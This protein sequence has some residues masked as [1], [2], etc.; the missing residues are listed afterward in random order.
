M[1]NLHLEHLSS[2]LHTTFKIVV[3]TTEAQEKLRKIK[4][5]IMVVQYKTTFEGA[6]Y[7]C[8]DV[9]KAKALQSQKN[10][11]LNLV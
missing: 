4:Q 8:I 5:T 7:E 9:S 11:G 6:L 2:L 1:A 10:M 3:I